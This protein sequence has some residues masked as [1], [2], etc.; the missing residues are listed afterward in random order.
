MKQDLQKMA[1]RRYVS[2][3]TIEW[4]EYKMDMNNF[5]CLMY[6]QCD[7]SCYGKVFVK[8]IKIDA[9][10]NLNRSHE[11]IENPDK[12]NQ[13]DI[14]LT[15]KNFLDYGKR[16]YE[17]VQ[18]GW[19]YKVEEII[20]FDNVHK[21]FIEV[22][23]S[24]LGKNGTY[25][26]RNIRP[27]QNF[28][29]FLFCFV[30]C[31]NNFKQTYILVTKEFIT[32]NSDFTLTPMNGTKKVNKDRKNIAFG[33]AFKKRS[34]QFSELIDCNLLKGTEYNDVF[35]FFDKKSIELKEQFLTEEKKAA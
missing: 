11:V 20:C 18:R 35:N 32:E 6:I 31:D 7:P 24:Y 26:I 23:I 30:D 21:K 17:I 25:T 19:S 28:D 1:Y 8:K 12:M 9:R 4:D 5:I 27:Y 22:K 10:Y 13:G 14:I 15:F 29:Y 2:K 3:N 34:F 16:D 33:T